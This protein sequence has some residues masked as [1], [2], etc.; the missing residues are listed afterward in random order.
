MIELLIAL[1]I[2]IGVGISPTPV[3]APTV[4]QEITTPPPVVVQEVKQEVVELAE[5][6]WINGEAT[7]YYNGKDR[8]NGE[9][10]IT[11]SGYSLD[12]GILYQDYRI[13]AADRS[14]PLGTLVELSLK[15]GRVLIG[16][17]LDRGGMITENKFDIVHRTYNECM[18]FGRQQIKYRIVGKVEL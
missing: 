3:I 5:P 13:L 9:S 2:V 4:A 16:I 7:A 10:G 17:V 11:A 15:D 14:I 12:N 6:T 8:M 18:D 1:G